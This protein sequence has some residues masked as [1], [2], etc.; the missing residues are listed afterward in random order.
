MKRLGNIFL[1]ATS[2]TLAGCGPSQQDLFKYNF[3]NQQNPYIPGSYTQILKITSLVDNLEIDNIKI[4]NGN[5]RILTG[6]GPFYYKLGQFSNTAFAGGSL[7]TKCE[8]I[9]LTIETKQGSFDIK[10]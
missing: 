4:N 5:C 2:L 10:L 6:P 9:L 7:G 1:L 8:P 3:Y